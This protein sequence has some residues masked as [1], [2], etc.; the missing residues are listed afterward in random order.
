MVLQAQP[1]IRRSFIA[2]AGTILGDSNEVLR[3]GLI[4]VSLERTED[5]VLVQ[6]VLR[7]QGGIAWGVYAERKV[8]VRP[9]GRDRLCDIV[10]AA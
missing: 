3:K 9:W 7:D 2:K 5:C 4:G 10:I 8:C 6:R 1:H